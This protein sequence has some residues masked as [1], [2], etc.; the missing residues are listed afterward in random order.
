MKKAKKPSK[1]LIIGAKV[2]KMPMEKKEM[3]MKGKC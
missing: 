1:L 2:D 3:K